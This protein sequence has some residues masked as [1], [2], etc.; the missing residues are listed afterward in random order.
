MSI[1]NRERIYY[2]SPKITV[3]TDTVTGQVVLT[4]RVNGEPSEKDLREIS[5][6]LELC[7]FKPIGE[8]GCNIKGQWTLP[9]KE[10]EAING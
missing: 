10:K 2:L 3:F 6:V 7:N 1:D 8:L 5:R 9:I 4:I